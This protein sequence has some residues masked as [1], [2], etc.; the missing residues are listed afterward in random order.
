MNGFTLLDGAFDLSTNNFY[1]NSNGLVG[2]WT[3]D[4]GFG[5]T[6]HDSSG[7]KNSGSLINSPTWANGIKGNSLSFNGSNQSVFFASLP[8]TQI[9]NSLSVTLWIKPSSVSVTQDFIANQFIYPVNGLLLGINS[10]GKLRQYFGTAIG[11]GFA[12]GTIGSAISNNIWT[13]IAY[14]WNNSTG[15]YYINGVLDSTLNSAGTSNIIQYNNGG[16]ASLYIGQDS[17]ANDEYFHGNIDD[18]RFYNR[19]LSPLEIQQIYFQ[20][21]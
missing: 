3:F 4:E 17:G 5:S 7:H 13:H 15:S 20:Q 14:T 11:V 2:Y 6:V 18:V 16:S 9:T 12:D 1:I 8:I 21:G 10:N 19:I